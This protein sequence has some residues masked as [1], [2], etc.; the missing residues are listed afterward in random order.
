MAKR[1][2]KE[3]QNDICEEPVYK[4]PLKKKCKLDLQQILI[5]FVGDKQI[6]IQKVT[7][8]TNMIKNNM[9]SKQLIN[10][11]FQSNY[12]QSLFVTLLGFLSD[13]Y[14]TDDNAILARKLLVIELLKK[15]ANPTLSSSYHNSSKT[16]QKII[17]NESKPQ[18][19]L[20]LLNQFDFTFKDIKFYLFDKTLSQFNI[21]ILTI[22]IQQTTWNNNIIHVYFN[23]AINRN[24]N[25]ILRKIS[26]NDIREMLGYCQ[27]IKMIDLGQ[28][29]YKEES[30]DD[31][32]EEYYHGYNDYDEWGQKDVINNKQTNIKMF[33]KYVQ[34]W[35][36][37]S[38]SV[39][40]LKEYYKMYKHQFIDCFNNINILV[41]LP[42]DIILAIRS[43]CILEQNCEWLDIENDIGIDQKQLFLKCSKY[44]LND[45][46]DIEYRNMFLDILKYNV[47]YHNYL[48]NSGID[49]FEYSKMCGLYNVKSTQN[50]LQIQLWIDS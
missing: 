49:S 36:R 21:S 13:L 17:L 46:V 38:L 48:I 42:M 22:G 26:V 41:S 34:N 33:N 35:H 4:L 10:S 30:D 50:W 23:G 16:N 43:F 2:L 7:F 31:Y 24:N 11:Y 12:Q 39:F 8:I 20:Y 14:I 18:K 5:N 40:V 37:L 32:T 3:M 45:F 27:I 19:S 47:K 29:Y 15:G 25:N 6:N 1:T 9:V 44:F 28:Q